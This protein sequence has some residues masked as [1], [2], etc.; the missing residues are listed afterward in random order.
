MSEV[1][2]MRDVQAFIRRKSAWSEH[3]APFHDRFIDQMLKIPG[4]L[5]FEGAERR[6]A[7]EFGFEADGTPYTSA[8]FNVKGRMRG[9]K[10]V[11]EYRIPETTYRK[12]TA[13]T[14]AKTYYGDDLLY[15]W[16]LT[17]KKIDYRFA[18]H[19]N[20]PT[21][22]EAFEGRFATVDPCFYH[23]AYQGGF[24]GDNDEGHDENGYGLA[25]NQTYNRLK[26]DPS[27][28]VDGW[29]NIYTLYPA[30]HW[31]GGRCLRALGYDR[32][33]VIRRLTG[34]VPLVRP[35]LDGVYIVLNDNPDITYDEYY[36]MNEEYK[37]LLGLV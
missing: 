35:L 13:E 5:G 19:E 11:G 22:I 6:A 25:I 32:D 14:W 24:H 2:D 9:V 36:A 12:D 31:E 3:I 37:K 23:Q 33:E 10:F 4:P 27:I 8:V 29:N 28:D 26:A 34:K 15:E 16:K 17:N 20:L 7:P 30:Q 21:V 18:L 1:S